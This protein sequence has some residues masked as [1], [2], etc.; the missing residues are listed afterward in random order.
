MAALSCIVWVHLP[1]DAVQVFFVN[2]GSDEEKYCL[3]LVSQL[4]K[5]GINSELYP[6]SAKMKKQMKYANDKKIPFVVMIGGNEMEKGTLSVKNMESGEQKDM[7][8]EE[9][10]HLI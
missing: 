4:R 10:T 9:L 5:K 7:T 2:F 6:A 3:P 1:E 8:L